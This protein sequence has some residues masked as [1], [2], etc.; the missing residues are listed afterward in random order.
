MSDPREEWR[1][2]PGWEG[3]YEASNTGRVRSKTRTILTSTGVTVR[4]PSREL[5][6]SP[7]AR[8]RLR[9]KLSENNKGHTLFLHKVLAETF[10][11]NP[12]NL[13][14]VRHL[15]DINDDNRLENLA[16]GTQSDN[17]HDKVRNGLHWNAVKTHCKNGHEYSEGNTQ[18]SKGKRNCKICKLE[19]QRRKK[20]RYGNG[21][22]T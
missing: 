11:P 21:S 13:P 8:G 20:G 5:K 18:R 19:W 17:M 1:D 22:H 10:L 12:N 7:D 9:V 4:Y 16:W 14:V 6:P 2:V 3:S 15:N